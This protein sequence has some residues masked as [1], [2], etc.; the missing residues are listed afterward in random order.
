MLQSATA[1]VREDNY[2]KNEVSQLSDDEDDSEGVVIVS[3]KDHVVLPI[4]I[5]DELNQ[6]NDGIRR[7]RAMRGNSSKRNNNLFAKNNV[8]AV[9]EDS[10]FMEEGS[11][12][13]AREDGG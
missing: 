2:I 4:D 10:V 5:S 9:A 1:H 3:Q 6:S 7:G 13:I 8:S 12:I 11:S